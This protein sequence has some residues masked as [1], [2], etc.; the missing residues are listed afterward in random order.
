MGETN[1]E[2]KVR[3]KR[4]QTIT[5]GVT[6]RRNDAHKHLSLEPMSC[7]KSLSVHEKKATCELYCVHDQ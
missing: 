1:E 3:S 5:Q 2:C 4:Q 7:D 6:H